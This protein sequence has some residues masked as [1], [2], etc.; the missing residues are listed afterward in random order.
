MK[1]FVIGLIAVM[2]AVVTCFAFTKPSTNGK[3]KSTNYYFVVSNSVTPGNESSATL[4]FPSS[5]QTSP[6][7][8]CSEANHHDCV[9]GYSG[10]FF[11]GTNFEPALTPGASAPLSQSQ[12]GSFS[13]R[14]TKD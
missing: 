6:P 1:K 10:W 12:Y 14:E 8:S 13:I 11:D 2:F 3:V 7:I 5:L 4:T 9:L